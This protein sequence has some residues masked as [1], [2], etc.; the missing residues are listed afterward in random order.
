MAGWFM[1]LCTGATGILTIPILS[2][3]LNAEMAGLW[4]SFQSLTAIAALTDFGISFAISRQAS[5]C[6]GSDKT[7]ASKDFLALGP[8]WKGVANLDHHAK[9]LYRLVVFLGLCV[10]II[11]YEFVFP[12]TNLFHGTTDNLRIAWYAMLASLLVWLSLGRLN[13]LLG[14][15][16]HLFAVRAIAGLFVLLQGILVVGIAVLTKSLTYMALG[17]LAST[18]LYALSLKCILHYFCPELNHTRKIGFHLKT[19]T[20]LAR[21]SAPIGVVN[22]SAFLVT[23]IQVPL[24]ATILGP[25]QVA[26]FY[27]AQRIGQFINNA[28]MLAATSRLPTF[29]RH[30]GSQDFSEAIS[31]MKKT[32]L[33]TSFLSL[34]SA[35]LFATCAPFLAILFHSNTP[36]VPTSVI[37]LMAIDYLIVSLCVTW[38]HFVLA[39]GENPFTYLAIAGGTLNLLLCWMVVPTYGLIAIP[40]AS[41]ISGALTTYWGNLFFGIRLYRKIKKDTLAHP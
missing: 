40:I 25:A 16:G 30:L 7:E 29:T 39:S 21:I 12:H 37:L 18:L 24:I 35:I 23:S 17:S 31:V 20:D 38:G 19:F 3:A 33:T 9:P 4:F 28:V 11:L 8:G 27:L 2:S 1:Q 34:A 5:Y 41:I 36:F 22:I 32:I 15:T 14:G 13:A 26:P 6:L 10:G